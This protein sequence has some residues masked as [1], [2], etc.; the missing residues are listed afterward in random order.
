MPFLTVMGQKIFYNTIGEGTPVL[1]MHGWMQVGTE[2]SAIA[3]AL[4][5]DGYQF[6][7]PDLPGYGKSVPPLR[8]YPVDFYERDARVMATFLQALDLPPAHI[9]GFS[10]GG[11]VALLLPILRPSI[12]RSVAAWGAIG[13]FGPDDCETS[14]RG[15]PPNWIT[16][17]IRARHPGQPVDQWPYAWVYAFCAL[18]SAG[19]DVSL[20][21]VAANPHPLLLMLGDQDKLNPVAGGQRYI[22]AAA[23]RAPKVTSELRVFPNV[24]HAIHEQQFEAFIATVRQFWRGITP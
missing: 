15:L 17:E 7:L 5:G 16:S 3:E 21:R 1:L 12:C 23:A 18:T 14:R 19:G 20:G 24:G 2:L 11:E 4:S 8:T 13:A 10:D 22:E 6:I 9:M